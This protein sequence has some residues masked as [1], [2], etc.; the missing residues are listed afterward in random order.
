MPSKGFEPLTK[1]LCL[2]PTAFAA[3]SI[4]GL[5]FP[6]ALRASLQVS[7][8]SD[9]ISRLCSGLSYC[10]RNLDFPEFEKFYK[11]T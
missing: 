4:C 8:H 7:T 11:H 6:F 9:K 3:L 2:P 1:G 5:D 10:F